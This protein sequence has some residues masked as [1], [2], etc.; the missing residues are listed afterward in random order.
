MVTRAMAVKSLRG[1]VGQLPVQAD[2]GG[3][4]A[5]AEEAEEIAVGRSARDSARANGTAR[6]GA[7]LD[8]DRLAEYLAKLAGEHAPGDVVVSARGEGNDHG[9][10]PHRIRLLSARRG[11]AEAERAD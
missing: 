7:V 10:G 3:E 2:I 5:A 6:A 11:N 9:D 4:R 1:L 8:H